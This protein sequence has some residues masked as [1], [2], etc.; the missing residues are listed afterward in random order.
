MRLSAE[1]HLGLHPAFP[2]AEPPFTANKI[3]QGAEYG[4]VIGS[5]ASAAS[6]AASRAVSWAVPRKVPWT[7][8]R[9]RTGLGWSN[10]LAAGCFLGSSAC[11]WYF[12][13]HDEERARA[14]LDERG[15]DVPLRTSYVERLNRF[16]QDNAV[17]GGVVAGALGVRLLPLRWRMLDVT[18]CI[19]GASYG[20]CIANVLY[21]FLFRIRYGNEKIDQA[22]LREAEANE[23]DIT[24]TA[25]MQRLPTHVP[26]KYE[27]RQ[28]EILPGV[29]KRLPVEA[30]PTQADPAIRIV[31]MPVEDVT[32]PEPFDKGVSGWDKIGTKGLSY[33]ILWDVPHIRIASCRRPGFQPHPNMGS[34]WRPSG[35]N[36]G[37]LESQMHRLQYLRREKSVQAEY[38]QRWLAEREA[39]YINGGDTF[40]T[41][42]RQAKQR[43]LEYLNAL[44]AKICL[45]GSQYDWMIGSVQRRIAQMCSMEDSPD[46]KTVTWLPEISLESSVKGPP[47]TDQIVGQ[48]AFAME[49]AQRYRE[50]SYAQAVQ[51]FGEVP[52]T[53]KQE[54]KDRKQAKRE[55]DLLRKVRKDVE[56]SR[57]DCEAV[58]EVWEDAKKRYPKREGCSGSDDEQTWIEEH[59]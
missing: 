37:E 35:T 11:A 3:L 18:G 24:T 31:T 20:C 29:W 1:P 2:V 59:Y 9:A 39:E 44:H 58:R 52:N 50:E 32:G 5:L 25:M 12:G 42:E 7:A 16:D 4:A 19:A 27:R 56:D 34:A 30:E 55:A 10:F 43:Y 53:T 26:R 40:T 41:E 38:V 14:F 51:Q 28:A 8:S 46:K 47:A 23:W 17:V 6:L 13:R 57:L 49:D 21:Y 45:T 36:V 15:I 33:P 54:Q 22:A 48:D